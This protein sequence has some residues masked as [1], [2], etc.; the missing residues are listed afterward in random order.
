MRDV[1]AAPPQ[2]GPVMRIYPWADGAGSWKA[3]RGEAGLGP[4][5]RLH[6]RYGALCESFALLTRTANSA[7]ALR[8]RTRGRLHLYNML[9]ERLPQNFEHVAFEL[10]ELIEE[11]DAMMRTRHLPGHGNLALTDQADV[12]DG[13]VRGVTGPG[14]DASYAVATGANGRLLVLIMPAAGS[15]SLIPSATPAGYV[16]AGWCAPA[17]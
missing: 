11:E 17:P 3:Q 2:H 9:L 12:G 13:V 6:G 1:A 5:H 14:G 7:K 10:R 15:A 4:S 8:S 16:V